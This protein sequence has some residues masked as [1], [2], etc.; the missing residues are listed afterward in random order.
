VEIVEMPAKL[1]ESSGRKQRGL[2]VGMPRRV[3][4]VRVDQTTEQHACQQILTAS[5]Q[6][7]GCGL[8]SLRDRRLV[9]QSG[10]PYR[11]GYLPL[12]PRKTALVGRSGLGFEA[13]VISQPCVVRCDRVYDGHRPVASQ[14]A[15]LKTKL[16]RRDCTEDRVRTLSAAL[17]NHPLEAR[18]VLTKIMQ[19]ASDRRH[20]MQCWFVGGRSL[21]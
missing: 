5:G 3:K 10:L 13:I 11:P 1:F 20:L 7:R 2:H 21:R 17:A 18:S 9:I 6:R 14:F 19:Q 12:L 16:S 4:P 15:G 8:E